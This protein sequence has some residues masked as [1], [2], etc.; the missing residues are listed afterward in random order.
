MPQTGGEEASCAVDTGAFT[1]NHCNYH[2]LIKNQMPREELEDAIENA[3]PERGDLPWHKQVQSIANQFKFVRYIT[4]A[5]TKA[6]VNGKF[7]LDIYADKRLLFHPNLG[8]RKVGTIGAFW[9]KPKAEMWKD[10]QCIEKQIGDALANPDLKKLA[11]QLHDL[12]GQDV[13]LKKIERTLAEQSGD[14]DVQ[15][16]LE[17][18]REGEA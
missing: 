3:M 9:E 11:R 6:Y 17:R 18:L 8:L 5:K 16:M 1:A 14:E 7:V 2:L 4:K 15:A 13:P 10:I 12:V